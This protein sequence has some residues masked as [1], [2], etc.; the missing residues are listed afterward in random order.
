[1]LH[2]LEA[3][4]QRQS[5]ARLLFRDAPAQV[6]DRR[7][8]HAVLGELVD[9]GFYLLLQQVPLFAEVPKCGGHEDSRIAICTLPGE[10][11]CDVHQEVVRHQ[12]RRGPEVSPGS[13]GFLHGTD[14]LPYAGAALEPEQGSVPGAF[15][16]RR[17]RC[18]RIGNIPAKRRRR[19]ER[20]CRINRIGVGTWIVLGSLAGLERAR[21][22]LKL[23]YVTCEVA[24]RQ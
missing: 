13:E 20:P 16:V 6:D 4:R 21:D 19:G 22:A 15:G 23:P 11:R 14:V 3:Q 9:L 2:L 24:E 10:H 8:H 1:M 17:R 7:P 18:G 12:D 5:F